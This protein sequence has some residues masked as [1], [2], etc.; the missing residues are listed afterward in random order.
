MRSLMARAF[1]GSP[2]QK[3]TMLP[4]RMFITICGGGTTT[5]RTSSK[6]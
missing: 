4:M 6:G 3:P 5:V 2:T 1:H